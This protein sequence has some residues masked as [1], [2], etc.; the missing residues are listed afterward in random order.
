MVI[1]QMLARSSAQE[2][3]FDFGTELV[4]GEQKCWMT[5]QQEEEEKPVIKAPQSLGTSYE[6]DVP[7]EAFD[8]Q[9]STQI[10]TGKYVLTFSTGTTSNNS[11][12]GNIIKKYMLIMLESGGNDSVLDL[13]R[14][15]KKPALL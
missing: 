11:N 4:D 9:S 3:G 2:I 7:S 15:A 10:L 12:R 14:G 5:V 13:D 1:N 8:C 6:P